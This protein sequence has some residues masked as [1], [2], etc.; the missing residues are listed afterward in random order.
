MLK[1]EVQAAIGN[2]TSEVLDNVMK[3]IASYIQRIG[4]FENKFNIISNNVRMP[5]IKLNRQ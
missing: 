3:K 1:A 5:T 2:V 4:I